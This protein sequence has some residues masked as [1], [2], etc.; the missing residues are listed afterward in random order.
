MSPSP[1]AQELAERSTWDHPAKRNVTASIFVSTYEAGSGRIGT[2]ITGH[3]G[4]TVKGP[5]H[6]C[7]LPIA[8]DHPAIQS[9]NTPGVW[10]HVTCWYDGGPFEREMLKQDAWN[11]LLK[12]PVMRIEHD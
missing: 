2:L 11:A 4:G 7:A 12:L 1:L 9:R 8:D 6:Y 3:G 5:C 10:A